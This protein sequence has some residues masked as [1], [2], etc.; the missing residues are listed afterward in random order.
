MNYEF[1]LWY[2]IIIFFNAL[3]TERN[4][5][6]YIPISFSENYDNN[7]I[8]ITSQKGA[9]EFFIDLLDKIE[10]ELKILIIKNSKRNK[11]QKYM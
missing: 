1:L 5:N 11:I 6:Y 4:I 9:Q 3:K 7:I 2:T 8:D 10:K